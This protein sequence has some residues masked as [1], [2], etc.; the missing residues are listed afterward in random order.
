MRLSESRPVTS[1]RPVVASDFEA[2]HQSLL[3]TLDPRIPPARWRGLFS[4][5]WDNPEDHV[6]YGLFNANG[7]PVG[8]V[9][10]LYSRQ[11]VGGQI[12]R[13]CNLS[14]WVVADGHGS[15][16]L[17]LIMPVLARRDLTIT[18]LTPIPSVTAIFRKLGFTSLES[19]VVVF[20]P[21][22][23]ATPSRLRGTTLSTIRPGMEINA[24]EWESRRIEDHLATCHQWWLQAGSQH[25]HIAFTIGR[26]RG[27]RTLRIH[28][29]S[30]PRVFLDNLGT[31]HRR[32]VISFG[33]VYL[34]CD[35]RLLASTGTGPGRLFPLANPRLFRSTQLVAQ[36]VSNLYSELP[37]LR[38]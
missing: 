19:A 20:G 9:A 12:H 8:F 23:L 21:R 29:I 32:A 30:H 6:G 10:T 25:C 14:S 13:F 18:N 11:S 33:A 17:R 24:G 4:W 5:G 15:S 35:A 26:R 3:R 7:T 31:V 27:L 34:E 16:S 37:V 1:L 28:S 36:D 38:L 2:I 22:S